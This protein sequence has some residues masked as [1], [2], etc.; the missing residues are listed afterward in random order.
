MVRRTGVEEGRCSSGWR[1]G[2]GGRRRAEE[3]GSG[4]LVRA[5]CT[6]TR[7][8]PRSRTFPKGPCWIW[9]SRPARRSPRSSELRRSG[10]IPLRSLRLRRGITRA[11][12]L[13]SPGIRPR[14]TGILL[15]QDNGRVDRRQSHPSSSRPKQGARVGG[16]D[17]RVA[18]VAERADGPTAFAA[19]T[20]AWHSTARATVRIRQWARRTEG[21]WDDTHSTP[22]PSRK[23]FRES[24]GNRRS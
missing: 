2:P 8:V 20:Y 19:T 17:R 16:D 23:Y 6:V 12:G 4:V 5:G 11:E 18:R 10:P 22:A 21:H 24:S 7:T 3:S 14:G 15:L 1:D 13:R 9:P